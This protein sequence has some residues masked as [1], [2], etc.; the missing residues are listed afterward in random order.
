MEIQEGI[1]TSIIY[2]LYLIIMGFFL[3]QAL[4]FYYDSKKDDLK[5]TFLTSFLVTLILFVLD[6]IGF[7]GFYLD[8]WTILGF[9]LAWI[10][11]IYRHFV[12]KGKYNRNNEKEMLRVSL[13]FIILSVLLY[14]AI[15]LLIGIIFG[16]LDF[17]FP[18][19]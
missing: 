7:Q 17:V 13:G 6:I 10:I 14:L 9:F 3:Q 12:E 2:L 5:N 15:A 16:V 1:V 19:F 4:R 11:I 8:I 18:P